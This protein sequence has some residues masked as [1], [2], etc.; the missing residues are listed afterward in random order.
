MKQEGAQSSTA[1]SDRGDSA[2]KGKPAQVVGR[3]RIIPVIAT[4]AMAQSSP[5]QAGK[6]VQGALGLP[7]ELVA[8][9]HDRAVERLGQLVS[10]RRGLRVFPVS[11][12]HLTLPTKA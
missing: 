10:E 9:W 2:A 3:Y 8:N 6:E 4:G 12:T 5:L 11:Y 1:L 7:G